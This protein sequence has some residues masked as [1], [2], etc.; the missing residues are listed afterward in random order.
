MSKQKQLEQRAKTVRWVRHG[1]EV[2]LFTSTFLLPLS[3]LNPQAAR[4]A[5]C[6]A[7]TITRI[8]SPDK[9]YV[10]TGAA[11]SPI[12]TGMY[13]GYKITNTSG[14]AYSD[15]WVKLENFSGGIIGLATN[16]DGIAHVGPLASG[17]S[18]TVYAYLNATGAPAGN[19]AAQTHTVSLYSTRPDLATASVCGDP[20]SLVTE[21]TIKALANKITTVVSGPTPAALGGIVT[22]TING[23]TGTIGSA[24]IF[25]F[26]PASNPTWPANAYQ[27]VNTQIVLS[28]GNTGTYT[29]L[30]YLSGLRGQ[31][32]AYTI[33]YT[34]VAVGTTATPTNV[35]PVSYLSSGTQI[36][37]NDTGDN[38]AL[39]PIQP[40]V[41]TTTLS[42]SASP[43]T[44]PIGGIVT[45]T[46]TLNN[47]STN[48][49]VTLDDI[50]DRLPSAPGI[51]TYVTGSAR[52][53]GVAIDDPKVSGQTLTFLGLFTIPVG[54]TRTL[55]YQATI[56][57]TIGSYTNQA[58]GHV[59]STQIDT[60]LSTTDNMPATATVSVGS[61]D[62]AVTKTGPATVAAGSNLTYSITATNNGPAAAANVIIK[63]T[64]PTGTTF[65]NA[66]NGGTAASSVVTWPTI[67][68]LANGAS[69]TYQ[70]TVQAPASGTL[71]NTVSSTST[72]FDPTAANNNGSLPV[73]QVNT[74]VTP[75]ADL[76]LTKTHS[77]SF[78][79]GQNGT[80]TL[81]VANT[82]PSSAGNP[83]TVTDTL[84]VG[85]TFVSGT[86]TGWTCSA[87]G[88]TVTCTNPN[89]LASGTNSTITLTVAVGASAAPSVTNTATVA[90]TTND[91]TPANN[92]A[93]DPT[94]IVPATDLSITKTDG[95]TSTTPGSAIAY[96]ITVTNN[97]ASTV[98]SV[99]V[100]DTLPTA[101]QSPV[102]APSTGSYNSSTG[103]WTGLNL[104]S[105]QSVTLTISGTVA[106][107]A[108]GTLTNTA[109]VAPPAGTTDTNN[110][111]NSATDTTTVTTTADLSITKTD[112][113]TSTAPGSAIAYAIT[114]TNN[115]P[116]TV[117]SVTVNDTLPTAMQSPVFTTSTG[118]YNSGTGAWTGLTL[119]SGQSVTLTISG[120][121][122]PSATGTVTNTATVAPPSG[123]T[124]PTSGNNSATDTTTI[125]PTADLR[126]TKTVNVPAPAVGS[127]IIYT[128]TVTNAGPSSATG[129]AVQDLLPSGVTFSSATPSQGTYN[130]V[131]GRWTVGTIANGSSATLQ[132]SVVVNTNSVVTNTAEV[133]ASEQVDPN[134][135][136]G[137]NNPGENDQASV[138]TPFAPSASPRLQLVKRITAANGA[139]LSNV[140]DDPTS[141]ADN[142]PNWP[143]PVD[144]NNG[145]STYLKGVISGSTLRPGD[146]L[147]YTIYFLSDG[148][149]AAT[150][151]SLCD[152]VP[153]NSTFV[154]D[155]F[156]T[157]PVSGINLTIGAIPT[158]LTNVPDADGGQFFNPGAVPSVACSA[159][160]T[161]GAVVVNVVKSPA[162]LPN[163]TAPGT[164]NNSYGFIRFRVKIN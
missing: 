94:T 141:T 82:G 15:L 72:T 163:A 24:G 5:S 69:V 79:V 28:G 19:S 110:A 147:E 42:K 135:T 159:A 105:G 109:T 138:S 93:T 52:F 30:L 53:N 23:N 129:V 62:I 36:K 126:L 139:T 131:S 56:P 88:Q 70:V 153:S 95:Q 83:I 85:L 32:T 84:P 61:A 104:A 148:G 47:T 140:V 81:T 73:S 127:T 35:T 6:S 146:I 31:D 63:D 112:G 125:T 116:S 92:T 161:N 11:P 66:T 122:S 3:L 121:V 90:S 16:E 118:S 128:V 40:T 17:A 150:N 156:S 37:H 130:N 8:S 65:V 124:D 142:A 14:A 45:Y 44:L 102:F 39:P 114:V 29:N 155:S 137:N 18:T 108:S 101:M 76:S 20:F 91:P 58:V 64:L 59:G 74:T 144:A 57:N 134:S 55:T 54:G 27:L 26:T 119:A 75:S 158:N 87:V 89:P 68:S 107:S 38:V 111:N 132:I 48:S 86:G 164:P 49:S 21:Q 41:N 51:T 80:Y 154:P 46:V 78:T 120:T 60:T 133:S 152:L 7:G 100:N 13:V 10:D 103:V 9:F 106:T 113:R 77:G 160:N 1:F 43:A 2:A 98:N 145:I 96:T 123:T 97:G 115:G 117:N 71:L 33:T 50:V 149:A 67:S 136:P 25:A 157:V 143:S 34:Y 22:E 12:P 151:I 4:A 99:T 162:N